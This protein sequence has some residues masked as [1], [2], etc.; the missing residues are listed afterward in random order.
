MDT[1]ER[2][3]LARIEA[4]LDE[5]IT[6]QE[7]QSD[8]HEARLRALEKWRYAWPTAIAASIAGPAAAIITAIASK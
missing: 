8:D 6:R 5:L 3:R 7:R 1:D 4:K 2:D